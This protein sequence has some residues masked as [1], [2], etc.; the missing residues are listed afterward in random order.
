MGGLMDKDFFNFNTAPPQHS[1]SEGRQPLSEQE[2][3]ARV[4]R[5]REATIFQ[6]EP[7]LCHLFPAGRR[8]GQE[9]Q[10]GNV[11]GIPGDSLSISL[12]PDKVGVWD[13]FATNQKGGDL[14]GLWQTARNLSFPETLK[15]IEAFLGIGEPGGTGRQPSTL[16][17][18]I[19]APKAEKKELGPPTGTWHYKDRDGR[20]TATVKRFDPPSGGKEFRPWD[21]LTRKHSHPAVR[22]LYNIPGILPASHVVL[23]EGEKCAEA[24]IKL[25]TPATTAMGGSNAP[26]EKTDWSPL[27]GKEVL[28]WPDNDPPNHLGLRPGLIYAENAHRAIEKAGGRPRILKIPEGKPDKWDAADAVEDGFDI[29][30][31]LQ[32]AITQEVK[33]AGRLILLDWTAKAYAGKAPER[34]WLV[35]HVFPMACVS[36][37]A[38]MGDAGKG[39]LGI[40]LALKVACK[41]KPDALNAHPSAFGND[42][43]A[44]GTAVILTAEDDQGEVHRRLEQIDSLG[45]RCKAGERLIVVPL[46]NA[47]GPAPIVVPGRNGPEAT[48]FYHVIQDQL[49]KL[50]DLRLVVFDPMACFVMADVTKDPAAG[51]FTTGLLATLASETGAAVL[52]AH[53]M[54]KSSGE[55]A[56][57]TP[58]QAR[59]RIRGTS[60]I[61]DGVRSAYA[62]WPS[63][64]EQAK[65]I[66][67]RLAV[68]Y[69][70]NKVFHGSIVKSNGPAD[71]TVKTF[72]RQESGL[73][74]VVD[75]T[76][77][78]MKNSPEVLLEILADDIRRAAANG[79]PFV[80]SGAAGLFERKEELSAELK[81]FG[82][83]RL[84][85]MAKEL[86]ENGTIG[87]CVA[88]GSKNPKWLDVPGGQFFNGTGIFEVG[89][90][91]IK[92]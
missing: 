49:M 10:V 69:A 13:D 27:S 58:E 73:L 77:R 81:E 19:S 87:K 5:I 52:I 14:I 79:R 25:G 86:L 50:P 80:V 7:I 53:H 3:R 31:F 56:I 84:H 55:K 2:M 36:I 9:F 12:K 57:S 40:D 44:H 47:G 42:V 92:Q 26:P 48:P 70:R 71:R 76:L 1:Q 62:L 11:Y 15:E 88:S 90:T 8:N 34:Q 64:H 41:F 33:P 28:I 30:A 72:V 60:A 65:K 24:L 59:E 37:L 83:D 51:S 29:A 91:D 89:F 22:P 16:P 32:S 20:I 46:P 78:R 61:V 85:A 38:A 82:R 23:V 45:K 68:E 74:A 6:A 63:D 18:P 35:S 17:P 4:E 54:N 21:A 43:L 66:C 39:M 75:D 67:R